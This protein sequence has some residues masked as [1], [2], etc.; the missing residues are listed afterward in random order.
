MSY[1]CMSSKAAFSSGLDKM[2]IEDSKL[3]HWQYWSH[4][5][6]KAAQRFPRDYL[7]ASLFSLHTTVH[8]GDRHGVS[9]VWSTLTCTAGRQLASQRVWYALLLQLSCR[10]KRKKLQSFPSKLIPSMGLTA[11][12]KVKIDGKVLNFSELREY[13]FK[14]DFFTGE[15]LF[16]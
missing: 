2:E 7:P 12:S 3:F 13:N 6:H 15:M 1:E 10:I 16:R 8:C 5:I 11:K 4:G 14:K 9:R